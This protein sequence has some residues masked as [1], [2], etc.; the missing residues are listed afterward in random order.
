MNVYGPNQDQNL[1]YTGVIPNLLNKID[2]NEESI[3]K[4]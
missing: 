2:S 1:A 3:N 4:W